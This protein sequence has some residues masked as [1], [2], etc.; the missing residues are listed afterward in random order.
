MI[1]VRH[2]N[3]DRFPIILIQMGAIQIR[4]LNYLQ[5][6]SQL[7]ERHLGSWF[8]KQDL[9]LTWWLCGADSFYRE[10]CNMGA[11]GKMFQTQT[12]NAKLLALN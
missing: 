8:K 10:N 6:S 3:G 12:Q 11:F 7:L 4:K 5:I 2:L 1:V 9:G